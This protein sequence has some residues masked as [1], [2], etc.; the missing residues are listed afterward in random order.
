MI[1]ETRVYIVIEDP[2][3]GGRQKLPIREYK[4][5]GGYWRTFSPKLIEKGHYRY[6]KCKDCGHG[7][8]SLDGRFMNEYSCN[9]CDAFVEISLEE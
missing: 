7:D 5:E 2:V 8:F 3:E 4:F 6:I 1:E 9:G